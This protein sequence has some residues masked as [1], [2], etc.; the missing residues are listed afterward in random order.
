LDKNCLVCSTRRL[1]H[2]VVFL[3]IIYCLPACYLK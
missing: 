2:V 1:R 3:M